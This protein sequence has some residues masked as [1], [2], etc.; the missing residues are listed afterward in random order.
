MADDPME[1]TVG[2]LN[3]TFHY[4]A[5]GERWVAPITLAEWEPFRST[6]TV[7]GREGERVLL[8]CPPAYGELEEGKLADLSAYTRSLKYFLNHRA[9]IQASVLAACVEFV[10]QLHAVKVH[11][12]VEMV[13]LA[14]VATPE[15]LRSMVDL[16]YVRL[17]PY[18]H[19]GVPYIGLSLEANWEEYGFLALLAGTEVIARGYP[20]TERA[21]DLSIREDGGVV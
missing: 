19:L 4:N 12:G 1:L 17:F 13:E 20:G 11:Y 2:D 10:Q 16:S 6:N 9:E 14:K 15:D 3:F 7:P 21:V 5:A 8:E 18:Q